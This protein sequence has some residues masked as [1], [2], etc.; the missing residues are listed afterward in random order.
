MSPVETHVKGLR[1]RLREKYQ[2]SADVGLIDQL[3]HSKLASLAM[4]DIDAIIGTFT[5]KELVEAIDIN[6]RMTMEEAKRG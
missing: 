4:Q 2:G 3:L 6:Q 1:D 5:P